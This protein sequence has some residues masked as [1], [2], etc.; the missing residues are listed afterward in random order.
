MA[1]GDKFNGYLVLQGEEVGTASAINVR[2]NFKPS[3]IQ[4]INKTTDSIYWWTPMHGAAG[5]TKEVDTGAGATDISTV[6]SD[7]ITVS[8]GGFILGT[9]VQT[10]SDV[11]YWTAWR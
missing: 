2:C 9:G 6:T 5:A 11:V 10:T 3:I 7:A 1:A 4:V 8:D